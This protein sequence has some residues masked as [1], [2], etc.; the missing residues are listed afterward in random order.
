MTECLGV[1][2]A[3]SRK[4]CLT[5][6]II[7]CLPKITPPLTSITMVSV[8]KV[9]NLLD[10]PARR[11]LLQLG[12]GAPSVG[13]PQ[14]QRSSTEE[15]HPQAESRAVGGTSIVSDSKGAAAV[16]STGHPPPLYTRQ[17]TQALKDT[18]TN[19]SLIIT[20]K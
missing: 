6:Q 3:I 1:W 10:C 7:C 2:D 16:P 14:P 20:E 17:L 5:S 15:H 11:P 18:Y 12:D 8:H 9:H 4:A 19:T 13:Q